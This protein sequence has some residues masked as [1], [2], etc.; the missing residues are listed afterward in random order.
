M[1]ASRAATLPE[2][3]PE[4]ALG[5]GLSAAIAGRTVAAARAALTAKAATPM[6]RGW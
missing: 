6:R 5:E 3:A 1:H 2:H 4:L